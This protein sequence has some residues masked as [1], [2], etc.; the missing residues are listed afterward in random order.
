LTGVID[1][2]IIQTSVTALRGGRTTMHPEL[3]KQLGKYHVQEL[4]DEAENERLVAIARG[5]AR[6]RARTGSA[7]AWRRSI[8]WTV[9]ELGI[10]LAGGP[11]APAVEHR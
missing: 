8:G 2:I 3:A 10:R 11:V 4:V 1:T 6:R 9:I 5:R 7:S